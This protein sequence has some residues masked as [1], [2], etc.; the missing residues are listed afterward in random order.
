M[1]MKIVQQV[2]LDEALVPHARRLRIGKSNFQLRS[3]I[4]SKESTLQVV[5]DVLRLTLFYKAF[6]VTSNVTEIYMQEFWATTT[7]HHHSI[8]F[9]MNN[10]KC[11]VNLE[12]VREMLHICPRIHNQTFNE[13]PF[14]EEILAFL[15]Y[16]G[17]SG[18]I[19]KITN[20]N[21]N[22]LHQPWRSF[23]TVI[24]KCLSGKSTGYD[25]LRHQNTQKFGAMLPIE[26]TSEDIRNSAA[27][28][29]YYVIASG[30]APPKTKASVRKTQS[31]SDTTMP[32]PTAVGT[33]LSTSVK[34]KQLAKSS[35]AKG[36][37]VCS[38][39]PL[40][41]AEQIKLATKKSLQQTHISQASRSGT[42]EGTD[43]DDVD[44][45]SEADDD[46]DDEDEQDDDDKNDNDDDQDL[47]NDMENSDD[48]S[49]DGESHR[50]N[51]GGYEGPD[52]EDENE[53]L[54]RDVN[55]NLEGRDVQM[56][57]VHTTQVLEDTHVTLT[58]VNPD[59][60]QQSSSVSSEFVTSML[61]LNPDKGIDSLFELTHMVDAP[62]LT[63]VVPLL[64]TALTLP[65]PSIAIMSQ[66]AKA[67][68]SILGIV[69][70]YINHRMNEAV[71]VAVQIQSDRLRDEAQAENEYFLNKLDENIQK[72]IKEKFKEQVKTSYAVAADLSE[73]ELKKILIEKMESNKRHDDA[74]KDEEP[75]DGSDRGS[76]RRREGKEPESPSAPKEKASKTTGNSTE[77]SKSH[78]QTAS[79]SAPAE[80]PMQTTQYLEEPS[81]QEFETGDA[82]DQPITEA[83]YHPEWFHKQMKPLTPDHTL[84][85]TLL[86]GPTYELMKGSC[87]S[88]VELEFFFEEVYKATTN[89]LDWNNPEG[90][91]Y[92]HNL[93]K[94]IPLIPNSKGSLLEIYS[95]R[96]IIAVIELQIVKWQDYKHLDWITVHRDDDKLYKF[97]E[98]N[99]KRIRIQDIEDMLLLLG[100][101]MKYL[102]QT[103]WSRSEKERAAAMIQAIDKQLMTRRI[104]QSL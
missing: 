97:K 62:V 72:I 88:L 36:L 21:I 33:R 54:Y 1:D 65:P 39:V 83:S 100:I 7:V 80:E 56:T 104:M 43:D 40:T 5:Y 53:E 71:K 93:L 74:N 45:Q 22:K 91:Q 89:Q 94:P 23:A 35:K 87:K 17:H 9:K 50:M 61:N 28:K 95:K 85:P 34:G 15:R 6:L 31:S 69:D 81:H 92:I 66:F 101:Q 60:Q 18:E 14:E 44:D 75:S 2:A 3:E 49:N 58:P 102:P 41:E 78:Q 99:F 86:D 25:S 57:D 27:Y 73:L 29:E 10:E 76:K 19:K 98:D 24:K 84:T 67:V 13:L 79:K 51:V 47:D 8:R 96:R 48:E 37:Y 4:T 12:Y 63:A 77:R 70:R 90:Q 82:D 38:E 55:I 11:I 59:G 42:D 16:L 52:V 30:A 20:V 26:L 46:Q 32:P 68:S 103:I 64:V